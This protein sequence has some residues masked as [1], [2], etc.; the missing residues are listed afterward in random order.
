[1]KSVLLFYMFIFIVF[2]KKLSSPVNSLNSIQKFKQYTI[3]LL[4]YQNWSFV[5]Q[6]VKSAPIHLQ[7]SNVN[8]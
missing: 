3:K 7:S 1:M 8:F 6:W 4:M 5:S 2:L